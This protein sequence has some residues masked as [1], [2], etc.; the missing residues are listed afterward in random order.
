MLHD[1]LPNWAR[2]ER[3]VDSCVNSLLLKF[4]LSGSESHNSRERYPGQLHLVESRSKSN[5]YP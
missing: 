4:F 2:F 1:W 5:F 3:V